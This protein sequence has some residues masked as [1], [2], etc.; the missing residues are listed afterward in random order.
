[1]SFVSFYSTIKIML[2][3]CEEVDEQDFALH[4]NLNQRFWSHR[5]VK[6]FTLV[7]SDGLSKSPGQPLSLSAFHGIL[8]DTFSRKGLPYLCNSVPR[9]GE[10]DRILSFCSSSSNLNHSCITLFLYRVICIYSL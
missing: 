4:K 3:I 1:M 8:D 2:F 10:T 5:R 6:I 7:A 9:I